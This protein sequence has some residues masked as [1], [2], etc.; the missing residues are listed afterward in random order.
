MDTPAYWVF[1][2][3]GVGIACGL[4]LARVA[5]VWGMDAPR[6]EPAP[7][8]TTT[9]TEYAPDAVPLAE[10]DPSWPGPHQT[11]FPFAERQTILTEDN[12]RQLME[13][14]GAIVQATLPALLKDAVTETKHEPQGAGSLDEW[15]ASRS[16][17]PPKRIMGQGMDED[18]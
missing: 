5:G 11:Q 8:W 6:P 9:R 7:P 16:L 10:R 12:Q 3:F 4:I 2:A 13:E 17:I 14:I 15:Y 1:I 18:G